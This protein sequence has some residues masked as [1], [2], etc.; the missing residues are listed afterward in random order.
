[1]GKLGEKGG[2]ERE[3]NWA[4]GVVSCVLILTHVLQFPWVRPNLSCSINFISK[5]LLGINS[6]IWHHYYIV[7]INLW[8][9]I[10]I[11]ISVVSI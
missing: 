4:D 2:M 11:T 1:M 7:N 10:L 8:I 9:A 5:S 6:K 3:I